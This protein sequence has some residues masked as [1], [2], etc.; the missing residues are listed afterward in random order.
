MGKK[1]PE[2]MNFIQSNDPKEKSKIR[3]NILLYLSLHECN[4]SSSQEVM[5]EIQWDKYCH[6]PGGPQ[7][8]NSVSFSIRFLTCNSRVISEGTKSFLHL[9]QEDHQGLHDLV[10]LAQ[11]PKGRSLGILNT[12]YVPGRVSILN[13]FLFPS[14]SGIQ[15]N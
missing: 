10:C 6:Y 12:F 7:I 9:H 14:H 13:S 11:T 8:A 5:P 4:V 2:N 1:L 3:L 15:C